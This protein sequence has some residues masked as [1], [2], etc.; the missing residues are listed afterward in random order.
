MYTDFTC[1]LQTAESIVGQKWA[2]A[3]DPSVSDPS[4]IALSTG[5]VLTDRGPPMVWPPP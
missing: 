4:R 5:K 1:V 2:I 3:R